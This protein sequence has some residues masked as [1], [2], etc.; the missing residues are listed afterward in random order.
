MLDIDYSQQE[1]MGL[2]SEGISIQ[3]DLGQIL[4]QEKK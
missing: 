4:D 2:S 3:I 1:E